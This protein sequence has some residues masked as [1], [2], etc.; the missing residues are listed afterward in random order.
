VEFPSRPRAQRSGCD[1]R[2]SDGRYAR[3]QLPPRLARAAS[4]ISPCGR[5]GMIGSTVISRCREQRRAR[6]LAQQQSIRDPG[7]LARRSCVSVSS[8]GGEM[9]FGEHRRR[10]I[11]SGSRRSTQRVRAPEPGDYGWVVRRHG[12]LYWREYGGTRRSKRSSHGSSPTTRGIMTRRANMR[13]W[14]RSAESASGASFVCGRMTTRRSF[15]CFWSSR[16]ARG[17][18]IGRRLVHECT[19]FAREAGYRRLVLWTSDV[20]TDARRVYERAGFALLEEEPHS[21]FGHRLVGQNWR[22]EL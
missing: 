11:R 10:S 20:L 14:P 19:S 7:C 9:A 21:S 17:Q 18:G 13:G 12:D 16:G 22:L 2:L 15:V 5:G 1:A 8:C 3:P 4:R 6:S